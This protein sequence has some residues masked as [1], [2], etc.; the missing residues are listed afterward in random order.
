MEKRAIIA[1]ALTLLV[2]VFWEYQFGL[3]RTVE[4]VPPTHDS[5]TTTV[6]PSTP[7]APATPP[8]VPALPPDLQALPKDRPANLDQKLPSWVVEAPLYRTQ[9]VAPGA[10]INSFQLKKFRQAVDPDSPPMEMIP[11]RA[12]GYLPLA[13]DLL[14]HQDW[15]L[16]TIPFSSEAPTHL[17][18]EPDQPARTVSYQAEVEGQVRVTKVFTFMPE[19]YVMDVEVRIDNISQ[20]PLTDQAG[21][22]FFFQPYTT[23]AEE[24]SYNV[25]QFSHYEKGEGTILTWDDLQKKE[26]EIVLKAPVD[27][28]GYENN[29]FIQAI[30]PLEESGYQI[31]PRILDPEKRFLQVVYLTDPFLLGGGQSKSIK[32]RVYIGSKELN[33]LD[34]AGHNLSKAVDY[35][36]FTFL[37]KPLL[38]VLNWV[39]KYVHN[40]GVAI[41]LLTI[42]IKLVFW[43]LT[44]KSYESMQKMKKIQ[45]KIAQ[46]REK[47]KDDRE[48]LNQE[49]MALYKTYKVNPMGGC[50]PMVLQIPVFFALYRMLN[51]AVELRHEPFIWWIN[52][53]TAPDRLN[54]GFNLPYLGGLPVLTLLMGA[55]MFIQQ[56][57]TPTGGDPRQ[58]QI[59]LLMPVVF[60][61][62]FINFPSGL[63]L[64]WLVNNVLSI[65][66]QYWINRRAA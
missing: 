35:G 40:Y 43:P 54:I 9:I 47:Y 39:Y 62:F 23:V 2:F 65:A 17:K 16:S 11:T 45:P 38:H 10:R 28:A 55:S 20:Q 6:A 48:K 19:S 57:M 63:V 60:T 49:L 18:L 44:Q 52:D 50:L 12:S 41:I 58:E 53:L 31:I 3:Y 26:K 37:A 5:A 7:P 4:Q 59:M 32:M 15:R 33:Q 25:S 56:K 34:K 24:S 13:V 66:Q 1:F 14:G 64:Y 42:F 22:S 61:V 51:G 29:Y 21:I 36:W 30:M 27:W 46:V 8:G